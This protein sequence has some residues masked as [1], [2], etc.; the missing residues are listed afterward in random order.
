MRSYKSR[1]DAGFYRV[2]LYY[3]L[4]KAGTDSAGV[5]FLFFRPVGDKEGVVVV[6][7]RLQILF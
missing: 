4:D 7:S 6:V 5:F 3:F 1:G 2:S